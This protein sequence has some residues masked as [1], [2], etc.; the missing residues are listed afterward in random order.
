MLD[1]IFHCAFARV[2]IQRPANRETIPPCCIHMGSHNTYTRY[3]GCEAGI[4]YTI[5]TANTMQV[6]PTISM[7]IVYG[8]ILS[9][10]HLL[11]SLN[12]HMQNCCIK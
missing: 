6:K 3:R 1:I 2:T 12:A 5:S 11:F 8:K 10:E 9:L 7:S 4:L